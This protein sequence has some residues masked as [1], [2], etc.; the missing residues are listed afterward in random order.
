M[1]RFRP[2]AP[3]D[4]DFLWDVLHVALWD[5]PPA[6]LR[7]REVLD[8]REVRIYAE[9]WGRD[10]DVGIVAMAN[11]VPA[12]A[13]TA[14]ARSRSPCT[15]PIPPSRSARAADSAMRDF[16][17]PT[18]GW[19]LAPRMRAWSRLPAAAMPRQPP[20]DWHGA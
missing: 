15:P 4:Q 14:T 5:P 7:P 8:H 13:R 20:S 9:G 2:L 1:P 6:P 19:S 12:G 11:G 18:T 17:A 3:G 16:A 10:G